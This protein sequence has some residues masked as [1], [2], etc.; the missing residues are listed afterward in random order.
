MTPNRT[1]SPQ[2]IARLVLAVSIVLVACSWAKTHADPPQQPNVLLRQAVANQQLSVK[3]GYFAWTDRLQKPRGS[4]T[5]LMVSTPQGIISRTMAI[6]DR[7][8]SD[9][10]RQQDDERINRLLDPAKMRDKSNKQREDQQHIERLLA[11][12]PDAFLCE[13][14][15]AAHDDQNL[16]LDCSPDPKFSPANYESQILQGMKSKIVIDREELRI[17]RIEGT[18]FRDVNFGWGFLGRLNRGGHIEITQARV[19]GK[20]WGLQ[21]MQLV[22]DG[23]IVVVKSLHIEETETSWNYHSVSAMS[24]AQALEYLRNTPAKPEH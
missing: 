6:N 15:P 19:T 22:F 20:H 10:E 16:H 4:V 24:V 14:A 12:L 7:A 2:Q 18:L 11:A 9:D 21:R 13:Y 17:S 5:K 8:L 23:R 1:S 3:D